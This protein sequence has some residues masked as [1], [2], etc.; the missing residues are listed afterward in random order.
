MGRRPGAQK[1]TMTERLLTAICE[2]ATTQP[3]QYDSFHGHCPGPW[4][5]ITVGGPV[6]SRCDC[7]CHQPTHEHD[8]RADLTPRRS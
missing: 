7:T 4:K 5:V 8:N 1:E 2:A 3:D 6:T